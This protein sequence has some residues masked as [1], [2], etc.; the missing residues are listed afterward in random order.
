MPSKKHILLRLSELEKQIKILKDEI[1]EHY[2][3]DIEVYLDLTK[4]KINLNKEISEIELAR[5][6]LKFKNI[7]CDNQDCKNLSCPLKLNNGI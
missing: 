6:C 1:N 4:S 5:Q 3:E 7:N 2:K